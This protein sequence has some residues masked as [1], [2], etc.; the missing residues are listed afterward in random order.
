MMRWKEQPEYAPD[1]APERRLLTA[2]DNMKNPRHDA[3][4]AALSENWT[5]AEDVEGRQDPGR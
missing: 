4:A 3:T 2:D 5:N 1:D